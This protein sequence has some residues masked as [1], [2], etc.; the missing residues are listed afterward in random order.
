MGRRELVA[1]R[2]FHIEHRGIA[3]SRRSEYSVLAEMHLNRRLVQFVFILP[4]R[5]MRCFHRLY[6]CSR[7]TV[8]NLL[9]FQTLL[10]L[11]RRSLH[12][13]RTS[14]RLAGVQLG[15]QPLLFDHS[16]EV[17][18]AVALSCKVVLSAN[19]ADFHCSHP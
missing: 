2:L 1:S 18:S 15:V 6:D 3:F 11:Q 4:T 13:V 17:I 14:P 8:P 10:F 16:H 5:G 7:P 12:R 19:E 9:T